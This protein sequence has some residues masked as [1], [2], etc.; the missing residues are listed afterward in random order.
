MTA[1]DMEV[2]ERI[3]KIA[4]HKAKASEYMRRGELNNALT[5]L[6][7]IE[8]EARHAQWRLMTLLEYK[9]ARRMAT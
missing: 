3:V 2:N 7:I 1:N 5:A 4:I 6:S 9:S 8:D